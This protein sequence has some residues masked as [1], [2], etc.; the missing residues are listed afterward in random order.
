MPGDPTFRQRD[1]RLLL[2]GQTTSQLGAQVS[3]VAIP[4]LA[5]VTLQASPLQLGLVTAS[6][7]IAFA[8]IGLPAGAWLDRCRRRPV[9]VAAD[10]V[11]AALLATIPVAALL[12]TLSITHLVLVSLL[13]GAARVFF[14]VGY[15]SYLPSVVGKGGLLA[16]N[17]AMETIRAGGQ[18]AGPGIGGWAST[19][20]GAANVVLIQVAAFAVSAASL[21]AIRTREPAAPP[22][23][24]GE[25]LGTEIRRGLAFVVRTRLLR[26]TLLTSAACNFAFA[27]ASAAGFVFMVRTLGL[28]PVAIGVVLAFGS[29]AVMIGAA[30][31]P[32]LA[33]RFGSARIIWL[34]LA[35]TG[36]V[37]LLGPLAEPGW[38][39][40][41]LVIGTAT[42]E[43]G[44]IVYSVTNVTLRQ[45]LCPGHL[46][47][48]VN[49]T[50][51]FFMMGVFPIGALLGGVVGETAGPRA[52][53]WAAAVIIL[54]SPLPLCRALRG[55]RDIEE[56]PA[57][58]E[59]P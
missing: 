48:R 12:G 6:G 33:R 8:L 17:A 42:G 38:G 3:M 18:L 39:V 11:R 15:Q 1:F 41:L 25:R 44:Q 21:L 54:L 5:V 53:L 2:L 9:L 49:A 45:R 52:T 32:R 57:W 23:P 43:L 7:T 26:A 19:L 46:L 16:G 51:R 20:V 59:A 40:V 50:M 22:R 35:V 24:R 4:L 28:P 58:K 36:P 56:L 10:L 13:T 14:D 37:A 34:S 27:V 29:T 30:L 55:T 31:T 47:N